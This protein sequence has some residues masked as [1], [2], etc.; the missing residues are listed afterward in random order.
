MQLYVINAFATMKRVNQNSLHELIA[1]YALVHTEEEA[2]GKGLTLAQKCFPISKG[3]SD[4]DAIAM[5]VDNPWNKQNL[6]AVVYFV[7]EHSGILIKTSFFAHFAHSQSSS[8]NEVLGTVNKQL[9]E[10]FVGKDYR[11]LQIKVIRVPEYIR[12]LARFSST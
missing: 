8:S 12:I 5:V 3:Y 1:S 4:H 9:R 6:Y 7:E 10:K 2:V 11:N